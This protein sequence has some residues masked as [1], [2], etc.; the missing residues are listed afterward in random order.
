MARLSRSVQ[1][2][3]GVSGSVQDDFRS[4]EQMDK[5]SKFRHFLD[6]DILHDALANCAHSEPIDSWERIGQ[7]KEITDRMNGLADDSTCRVGKGSTS[8]PAR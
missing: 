7:I 8:H 1:E 4:P 2:Y 3:P 5:L 6:F